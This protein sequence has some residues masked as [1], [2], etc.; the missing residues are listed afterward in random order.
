MMRIIRIK[1]IYMEN[2][3]INSA[4]TA[5]PPISNSIAIGR[6]HNTENLPVQEII[7]VL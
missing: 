3:R 5:I 6:L 4:A 1:K 2:E 7:N